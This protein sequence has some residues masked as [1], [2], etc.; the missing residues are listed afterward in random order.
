MEVKAG[1][2]Q[3]EVGVIPVEWEV[4]RLGKIAITFSGGTPATSNRDYYGDEI[5]WI[6]SGDLNKSQILSVDGKITKKGLENS[7]AKQVTEG[8]LLMAL[9]GATAGVTAITRIDAAINQAVLAI[10]TKHDSTEYLIQILTSKKEWIIKTYTQG[11]QPNLSGEIVRQLLLPLP[12]LSEQRAIAAALSDVDA[13]INALDRLIAKKRNI[14][15]AAMQD[16]LTGKKRLPGFSE[17]WEIY[18]FEDI[19]KFLSTASNSRSDLTEIGDVKYIHYGDI[20]TSSASFLDCISDSLPFIK[21]DKVKNTPRLENG[22]LIMADASEDYAGIGKSIEVMNV[23]G[24]EIIAGLHTLLLRGDKIILADGFKGYLQFIPA[25]KNSL[26]KIATGISVYGVSKGN[27]RNIEVRLPKVR[28]QKKIA[29][30][31]SDMD[32]EI[33]ALEQ[34]REKTKSLKQGMMQELLTGRIRLV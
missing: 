6:T 22:D 29:T 16:L 9:Y 17:R 32:A 31:L 7:A 19:F 26:I 24:P 34:K 21:A 30:I 12:R 3:T 20:H 18:K 28:E 11:G 5:D 23:T 1:Y 13:L 14:K 10:I 4:K 8:T 27:V 2:K 25:V 33:A 15:Q